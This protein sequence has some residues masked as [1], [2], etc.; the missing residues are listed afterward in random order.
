MSSEQLSPFLPPITHKKSQTLD[1]ENVTHSEAAADKQQDYFKRDKTVQTVIPGMIS[2]CTRKDNKNNLKR[3]ESKA[4]MVS[5]RRSISVERLSQL[6]VASV[7][8]T[9]FKIKENDLQIRS[10][11]A[12][13]KQINKVIVYYSG[14]MLDKNKS[15]EEFEERFKRFQSIVYE[16]QNLVDQSMTYFF[17]QDKFS[18]KDWYVS[19]I[20]P[21]FKGRVKS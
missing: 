1:S 5:S 17:Q 2:P 6:N 18:N 20:S 10:R 12:T 8:R 7:V 19:Q 15:N 9:A 14:G 3:L 11:H 4:S 16:D 13:A 21:K